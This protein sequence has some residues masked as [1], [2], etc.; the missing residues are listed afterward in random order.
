M[1]DIII[2]AYNAHNTIEYTLS[3]IAL[4]TCKDIINVYIV[5]DCSENNYDYLIN[6]FKTMINI[7][8]I[9]LDVNKGS[10]VARQTGID[11]GYSPYI[12]FIDADDIY[13]DIFACERMMTA[14]NEH[15]NVY[16]IS[17]SFYEEMSH[18]KY[19]EHEKDLTWMFGKMYRREY[20]NK[21]NIRFNNTRANEDVGFHSKL[22]GVASSEDTAIFLPNLIYLW[23]NNSE[24]ITRTNGIEYSYN[25]GFIGY[26]NNKLEAYHFEGVDEDYKIKNAC[27]CLL[28]CY[29]TYYESIQITPNFAQQ[30]LDKTQEFWDGYAGFAYHSYDEK[31]RDKLFVEEMFKR[32]MI[33]IP[34]LTFYDFI[35]LLDKI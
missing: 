1:I 25:S 22:L 34:S 21:H 23:K 18:T 4:Q 29:A 28:E 5:D 14:M 9:R 24:S 6:K 33:V 7:T 27:C 15:P 26:I 16:L 8:I 19:I 31:E 17:S 10:G 13:I 2:P 32:H 20:L 3:S 11:S 35:K 12:M 30:I